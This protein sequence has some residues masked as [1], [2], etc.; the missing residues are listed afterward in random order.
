[1][2]IIL[3]SILAL[4]MVSCQYLPVIIKDAEMVDE[5]IEEIE[6]TEGAA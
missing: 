5:V 6:K 2:H 3:I 1:M 4:F